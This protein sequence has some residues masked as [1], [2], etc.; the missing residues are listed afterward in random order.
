MACDHQAVCNLL[1]LL[2]AKHSPD[3]ALLD[4]LLQLACAEQVITLSST[5]AHTLGG[6]RAH[7]RANVRAT[8]TH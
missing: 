6:S 5:H 2:H 1:V 3:A 4:C 8:G 7:A